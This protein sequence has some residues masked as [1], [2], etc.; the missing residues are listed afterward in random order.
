M[1]SLKR[2]R[3]EWEKSVIKRRYTERTLRYRK[4]RERERKKR[5]RCR[6]NPTD[7]CII[8]LASWRCR[9]EISPPGIGE[10]IIPSDWRSF[11]AA[12]SRSF[13]PLL[14]L[15]L[16]CLRP[17][18]P[19][20]DVKNVINT[21]EGSLNIW[22]WTFKRLDG[23]LSRFPARVTVRAV[24]LFVRNVGIR[25]CTLGLWL[26]FTTL[27]HYEQSNLLSHCS[28]NSFFVYSTYTF[29]MEFLSIVKLA[30]VLSDPG[31]RHVSDAYEIEILLGSCNFF[32]VNKYHN[33]FW[34]IYFDA[35]H[36]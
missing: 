36:E 7:V 21:R 10:P 11:S 5:W 4:E 27:G 14:F 17:Y 19:R 35:Y 23:N 8:K 29:L 1:W 16:A 6:E 25:M 18:E 32:V 26:N 28:V 20:A 2:E 22:R 15:I 34:H 13:S 24:Q 3:H 30:I 33:I 31:W 12:F 9:L